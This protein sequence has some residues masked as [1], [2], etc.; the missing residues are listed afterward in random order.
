M[1]ALLVEGA[2]LIVPPEGGAPLDRTVAAN[3]ER[4]D[5]LAPLDSPR[6]REQTDFY[7]AG[8]RPGQ[9]A[10]TPLVYTPG[11]IPSLT[12]T[13]GGQPL[14]VHHWLYNRN[15]TYTP[16]HPG[17]LQFRFGQGQAYQGVAQ[18]VQLG[19]ITNNPPQPDQLQS[20]L[21]GWG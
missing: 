16:A 17:G 7:P 21:A 10:D 13:L 6:T 2:K 19:E 5:G 8:P 15:P 4:F 11:G 9:S 3:F 18:T 20:I 14:P 1:P 12:N